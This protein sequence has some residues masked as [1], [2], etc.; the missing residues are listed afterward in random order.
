MHIV[1]K[2]VFLTDFFFKWTFTWK[3]GQKNDRYCIFS[4]LITFV[5]CFFPGTKLCIGFIQWETVESIAL[6][7]SIQQKAA[8]ISGQNFRR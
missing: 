6:Q 8:G 3:N 1:F 2:T 5:F 7:E 4:I